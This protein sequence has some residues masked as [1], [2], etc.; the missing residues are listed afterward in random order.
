MLVLTRGIGEEIV[1][2]DNIQVTVLAVN[3]RR[4]RL[5][6]TAPRS[7][8]VARRELLE[9]RPNGAGAPTDGTDGKR[10]DIPLRVRRRRV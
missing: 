10:R 9:G 1:I 7:V 2:A 4:V 3:G 5:G 6:V 8:P